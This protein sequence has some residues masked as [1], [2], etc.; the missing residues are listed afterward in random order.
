M[1]AQGRWTPCAGE[2][3]A[4]AE[5]LDPEPYYVSIL[6]ANATAGRITFSANS[7][8][9]RAIETPPIPHPCFC[10]TAA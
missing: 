7:F 6:G 5:R 1:Q 2:T 10:S 4:L 3:V 8:I 9:V